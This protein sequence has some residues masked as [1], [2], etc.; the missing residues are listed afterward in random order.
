MVNHANAI[1]APDRGQAMRHHD[2]CAPR[3]QGFERVLNHGFSAG[4]K[5]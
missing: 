1:S 2:D 4:I 5:I 3:H